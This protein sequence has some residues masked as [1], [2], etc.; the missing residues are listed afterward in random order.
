MMAI[1]C[2]KREKPRKGQNLMYTEA[3][4]GLF[5]YFI[6][7]NNA[8]SIICFSKGK[9][10]ITLFWSIFIPHLLFGLPGRLA[11]WRT[12]NKASTRHKA[13]SRSCPRC[14]YKTFQL[15]QQHT[16]WEIICKNKAQPGESRLE[17]DIF[18]VGWAVQQMRDSFADLKHNKKK[19]NK[20]FWRAF[21]YCSSV[22]FAVI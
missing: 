14:S 3:S 6:T 2:H 18:P 4:K 11:E 9:L 5:A 16:Q 12:S 20:A 7:Y 22:V 21:L 19:C 1:L 15:L 17:M 8:P 10:N 13:D